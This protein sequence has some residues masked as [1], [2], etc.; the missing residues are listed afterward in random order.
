M[1]VGI[2]TSPLASN[3]GGILQNYALQQVLLKMGHNPT[4]IDVGTKYTK[5]RWVLGRLRGLIKGKMEIVP[6]PWYNRI[7]T[8]QLMRFVRKHIV[9]TEFM[10]SI[11][12]D[13]VSSYNFN[14]IIVGS[15][16]V[17]RKEY[18]RNLYNMYLDFVLKKDTK[19]IAY[20]A[21][22]G[23]E[24][25][26]YNDE[27]TRK[28]QSLIKDFVAVS[29][30]ENSDVAL[31]KKNLGVDAKHV[32]DPTLLLEKDDYLK[33]CDSIASR[34]K[35]IVFAYFLDI[36]EEKLS[37]AK[38]IAKDKKGELIIR[39][40]ENNLKENETI[41]EWLSLFR[42]AEFIVTDSYHG[43][44][45]SIIFNKCFVT[46]PNKKRGMSRFRSVLKLLGLEERLLSDASEFPKDSIRWNIVNQR[47]DVEKIESIAFLRKSL[48]D[49]TV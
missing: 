20:A 34:N 13:I 46:L 45:F 6:F 12:P 10:T 25:W 16:Q 21:S 30:R 4:T 27:E 24:E 18:N 17:W 22:I 19:K 40:A 29:V 23:V 5:S 33:L 38:A 49:V 8:Y 1:K 47:L 39:S 14:A 28:C 31:C 37:L 41:E 32:L 35:R 7:G 11:S 2:L 3:I 43:T 48:G 44:L 36:C 9:R 26:D 15:D 42:D